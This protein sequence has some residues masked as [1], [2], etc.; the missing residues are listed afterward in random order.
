MEIETIKTEEV[1]WWA[2]GDGGHRIEKGGLSPYPVVV[3]PKVIG[4]M[5]HAQPMEAAFLSDVEK[6]DVEYGDLSGWVKKEIK[7]AQL[8]PRMA[9]F[10]FLKKLKGNVIRMDKDTVQ[11]MREA[12]H[13][14]EHGLNKLDDGKLPLIVSEIALFNKDLKLLRVINLLTPLNPGDAFDFHMDFRSREEIAA[15]NA[16]WERS[17]REREA[18]GALM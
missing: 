11:Q 6:G 5:N 4:Q 3:P 1:V 14:F 16:S 10:W 18:R 9:V 15:S 17:E 2:W 13:C 7:D 8:K 12:A